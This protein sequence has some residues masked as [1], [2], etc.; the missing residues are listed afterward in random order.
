MLVSAS[1]LEDLLKVL[2]CNLMFACLCVLVSGYSV[3]AAVWCRVS[4]G[5]AGER[6]RDLWFPERPEEGGGVPGQG[7]S[8]SWH[9]CGS[10]LILYMLKVTYYAKS[11]FTC[12]L[13][14]SMCPLCVKRFGMFQEQRF[15]LFLSWSIYIKTCLKMSWSDFGHFMMS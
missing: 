11:T 2:C 6:H 8:T 13:Y 10:I 1:Q 9:T 12:I 3:G 4:V 7:Q 5:P 14:I 15:S